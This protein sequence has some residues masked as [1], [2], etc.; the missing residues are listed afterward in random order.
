MQGR[1]YIS[2]QRRPVIKWR[3]SSGI[4]AAAAGLEH[5]M[6]RGQMTRAATA[7]VWWGVGGDNRAASRFGVERGML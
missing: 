1:W 5:G 6:V 2:T 4:K 7:G 3:R